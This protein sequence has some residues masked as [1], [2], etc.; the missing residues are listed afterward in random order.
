MVTLWSNLQ[1]SFNALTA[2]GS[3]GNEHLFSFERRYARSRVILSG[4]DSG[5][6][7]SFARDSFVCGNYLSFTPA[8]FLTKV[9]DLRVSAAP[10]LPVIP[11]SQKSSRVSLA[12]ISNTPASI[13]SC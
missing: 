6:T 4:I 13:R 2:V 3:A 7:G 1:N 12:V 8:F 11:M 9:I 5:I 10:T